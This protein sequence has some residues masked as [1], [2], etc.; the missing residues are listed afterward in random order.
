MD[1]IQEFGDTAYDFV[2]AN[3]DNPLF[4]VAILVV[5]LIIMWFA[6]GDLGNK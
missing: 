4:W 2:M 6:I 5:M 3:F 1:K